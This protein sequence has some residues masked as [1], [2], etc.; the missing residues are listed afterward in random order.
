MNRGSAADSTSPATTERWMLRGSATVCARRH[1]GQ[2]RGGHA[3]RRA[4]GRGR[5][6][7]RAPNRSAAS[8]CASRTQ[9]VGWNVLSVAVMAGKSSARPDLPTSSASSGSG[10]PAALV[11]GRVEAVDAPS[12]RTRS[13][14]SKIGARSW[15][16]TLSASSSLAANLH[17]QFRHSRGRSTA[18]G[19]QLRPS[20]GAPCRCRCH[21]CGRWCD[22]SHGRC[23]WWQRLRLSAPATRSIRIGCIGRASVAGATPAFMAGQDAGRLVVVLPRSAAGQ[24][25]TA[26][27]AGRSASGSCCCEP[28]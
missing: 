10:E 16:A 11:T 2:Q 18:T 20:S 27:P 1:G 7:R 13:S 22:R 5:T 3:E 24:R 28:R 14:V 4:G 21:W 26:A 12:V 17:Q 23:H 6:S 19:S 8:C 15:S 25:G 9:P